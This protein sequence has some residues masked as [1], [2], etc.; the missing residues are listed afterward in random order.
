MTAVTQIP[1]HMFNKGD[2]HDTI[3]KQGG[4]DKIVF[5]EGIV[6]GDIKVLH[7]G[8]DVL[9]ELGNGHDS[10]HLKDGLTAGDNRN[11]S[12]EIRY[13]PEIH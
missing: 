11:S 12:A 4:A 8:Q 13:G 7:E 9:L 10:I 1:H 3:V 6:A 5:G 2:G